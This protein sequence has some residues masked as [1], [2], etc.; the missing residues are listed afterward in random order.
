[1]EVAQAAFSQALQLAATLSAM[2]AIGAAIVALAML[3]Q[4]R[5]RSELAEERGVEPDRAL[6][7]GRPC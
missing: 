2:V 6:T 3:R 1:M 5:T 7:A 4:A